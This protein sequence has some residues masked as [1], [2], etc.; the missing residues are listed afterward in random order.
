MVEPMAEISYDVDQIRRA[1][2]SKQVKAD[3]LEDRAGEVREWADAW[4]HEARDLR[5]EVFQ[6]AERLAQDGYRPPT[7]PGTENA[8]RDGDGCA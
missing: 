2:L 6:L 5:V 7:M 8:Q 3:C 1:M 4:E